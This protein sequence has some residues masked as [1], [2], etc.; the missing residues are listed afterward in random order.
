MILFSITF[1]I[2]EVLS[3][4][5]V[6]LLTSVDPDQAVQSQSLTRVYTAHYLV[7]KMCLQVS[8][9]IHRMDWLKLIEC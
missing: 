4:G 5:F 1:Q 8:V 3:T 6:T 7:N 2:F 9:E